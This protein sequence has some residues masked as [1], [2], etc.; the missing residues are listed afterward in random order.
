MKEKFMK[1]TILSLTILLL[2]SAFAF[3]QTIEK[4]SIK[5]AKTTEQTI[6]QLEQILLDSQLKGTIA[7]IEKYYADGYIFT[8]PDALLITKNDFL[9]AFKTGTLKVE[10][11]TNSAMKVTV[12]GDTAIARF[13]STDKGIFN[14]QNISGTYQWTDV[15]VKMKGK[16]VLVSTHGTPING[17]IV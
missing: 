17:K 5:K 9:S 13:K 11:S 10:S 16:W 1:Q 7:D 2:L 14:G 8:A 15:F 4:S 6:V 12:Y 3:G